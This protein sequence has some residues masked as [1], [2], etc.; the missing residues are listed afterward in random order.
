VQRLKIGTSW[1]R[2]VVGEALTP[3]LVVDF[4]CAFGT[5]CDGGAVVIGRDTRGSSRMMRAAVTSGLLASGCEVIDLGLCSTPFVSFAV[6]ELGADGGISVT[7]SHNDAEWNALKFVGPDGALLNA[8]KSEELLDIYHASH[9]RLAAW[10]ELKPVA[11]DGGLAARYR[12]HLLA[13]LDVETISTRGFKVA[14][15][16]CNGAGAE[17]ARPFLEALG[18]TLVPVN[19]EPSGIFAHPPAPTAANMRVLAEQVTATRADIGAGLNVDGDRV[20]FVTRDGVALSEEYTLPIAAGARLR[21]HPGSIVINLSTSSMVEAVAATH[22]QSVRRAAVGESHVVDQG[23]AEGAVLAGE[24]SGGVAALPA[25][26][27]FDALLTLGLVLE[28]MASASL[29]LQ[30]LVD[31]LPRFTMRKHELPCPPNVVYKVVEAFRTRY[32]DHDPD[33]TDGVRVQ[34]PDAGWM[35]A[36]ASNTEPLLRVIVEAATPIRADALLTEA[37]AFAR[38]TMK[39]AGEP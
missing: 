29:S 38:R 19:E 10:N 15:D 11:G 35:H 17:T 2:G 18:A 16:F 26:L 14:V 8:V 13:A 27:T 36:R 24:G 25:S 31:R 22:K 1:V 3:D 23:M 34:F 21:R 9:F 37:L 20:G 30:E 6:R 4:A 12:A 39:A 33:C 7:G 5:W 32:A 28:E